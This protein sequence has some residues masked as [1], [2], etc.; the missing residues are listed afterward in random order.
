MTRIITAAI[1]APAFILFAWFAPPN[2]FA[3]LTAALAGICF[4][5][6]AGMAAH[7]G[8]PTFK[9]RGILAAALLPLAFLG[10]ASVV[11]IV[12]G[13]IF[14]SLIL[15]ALAESDSGVHALVFTVFGVFYVGVAF[16]AAAL[17]R[18]QPEGARL[19]LLICCATWGADIGAYYGGR[20][21]GKTPL[22]PAISP[23]KT[24]EGYFA[25]VLSA[26]ALSALF[27]AFFFKRADLI[28]IAGAGLVGGLLGPGGDLAESMLKRFFGVKDSG[29][30]LPG[31]GGLLDRVDALMVNAPIFYVFLALAGYLA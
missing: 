18:M 27:A 19:F 21:F 7:K 2:A 14:V 28:L 6:Y 15:G 25:G 16:S 11:M 23:N 12:A 29:T 4:A 22:A 1:L 24:V 26:V 31:H 30:I 17:I 13:I 3:A 20:M 9:K 10:S 5:E 8:I